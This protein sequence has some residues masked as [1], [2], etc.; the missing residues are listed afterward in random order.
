MASSRRGGRREPLSIWPGFVDAFT[1]LLLLVMFV[2]TIFLVVQYALRDTITA[3]VGELDAL[4][5]QVAGLAD[6]LGL[7]RQETQRLTSS[8]TP[9]GC[10]W[11]A[12]RPRPRGN[13][14]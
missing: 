4:S 11:R 1:T 14:R 12:N 8:W 9:P 5:Q 7:E 13:R 6:A 3:Q 2:L 10:N